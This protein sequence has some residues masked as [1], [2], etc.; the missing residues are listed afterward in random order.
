M[1]PRGLTPDGVL[2]VDKPAGPTSFDI[3][4]QARHAHIERTRWLSE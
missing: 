1:P 4:A 3:V 2:L